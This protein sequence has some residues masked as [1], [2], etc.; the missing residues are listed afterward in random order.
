MVHTDEDSAAMK[1]TNP[2]EL[3]LKSMRENVQSVW[4]L[5]SVNYGTFLIRSP[6]ILLAVSSLI[7]LALTGCFVVFVRIRSFD[8]TDFV[9]ADGE[10]MRNA[11]QLKQLFGNDAVFRAHQQLHLYPTLDIIMK[12]KAD[13]LGDSTNMLDER[14]LDE[15][16]SASGVKQILTRF[17]TL[18]NRRT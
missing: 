1:R 8:Q 7:A 17:E 18:E 4:K 5:C 11:R 2:F 6:W 15:V 14:I 12:R 16:R 10:S 9:M 13:G 3:R